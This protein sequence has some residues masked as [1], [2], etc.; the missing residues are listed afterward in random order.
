MRVNKQCS[1]RPKTERSDYGAFRSRSV[2][3]SFGFQMSEIGTIQFE[4]F[5][6]GILRVM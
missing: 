5:D 4:C 3:E 2:V 6:F 1:K